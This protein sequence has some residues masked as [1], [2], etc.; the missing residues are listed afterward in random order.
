[1]KMTQQEQV[2]DRLK[3]QGYITRN[4]ALENYITRLGAIINTLN[5]GGW[6]L[7]GTYTNFEGRKDYTYYMPKK[8]IV[9]EGDMNA[10]LG[11]L[12]RT[13]PRA[14]RL[15]DYDNMLEIEKAIKANNR[16]V[17]EIVIKKFSNIHQ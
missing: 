14:E 7:T 3:V 5:K 15:E 2:E 17:K 1:M 9:I 4:W 11:R 10:Q 6:N 16:Y 12:L 13:L 8:A